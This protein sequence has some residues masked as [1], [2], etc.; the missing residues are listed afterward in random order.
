MIVWDHTSIMARRWPTQSVGPPEKGMKAAVRPSRASAAAHVHFVL[1]VSV[2]LP[3]MYASRASGL[4]S[5]AATGIRRVFTSTQGVQLGNRQNCEV[6]R[7]LPHR[8]GKHA[9]STRSARG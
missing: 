6:E 1:R 5:A 2:P 9:H 3:L 4:L 7:R 8:S